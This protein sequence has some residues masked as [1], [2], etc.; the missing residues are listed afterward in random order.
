LFALNAP[1]ET[2]V[3]LRRILGEDGSWI[4]VFGPHDL[5]PEREISL[6]P[7]SINNAFEMSCFAKYVAVAQV[8]RASN[9]ADIAFTLIPI[10]FFWETVGEVFDSKGDGV[11][12]LTPHQIGPSSD[13]MEHEYLLQG[14]LMEVFFA[15]G[16]ISKDTF[17]VIDWLIDRISRRG[18]LAPQYGLFV[19]KRGCHPYHLCFMT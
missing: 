8:L 6:P 4:N 19:I 18:Y 12:L 1:A 3:H 14:G 16:E 17:R 2:V 15:F 9:A 11:V 10:F 7:S 5:G 13:E